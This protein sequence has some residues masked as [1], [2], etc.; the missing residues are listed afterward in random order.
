MV[1]YNT[2]GLPESIL[3]LGLKSASLVDYALAG[4]A[5]TLTSGLFVAVLCPFF[6][7]QQITNLGCVL[8]TSGVTSSGVTEMGLYTPGPPATLIDTTGDMTA[9]FAGTRGQI[10]QALSK[11]V[12]TIPTTD[13]YYITALTHFSGT[14]PKILGSTAATSTFA[15]SAINAHYASVFISATA[16]SPASFQPSLSTLNSAAY[17]FYAD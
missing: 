9:S 11:G 6:A 4:A 13:Q 17:Y 10:Q 5:F 3:G 8:D 1:N 15:F 2:G 7:G 16:S 14:A 12:Y